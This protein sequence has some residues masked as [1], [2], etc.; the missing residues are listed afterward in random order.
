MAAP[1]TDGVLGLGG[2]G[3][4]TGKW[5][6]ACC[7]LEGTVWGGE[8]KGGTPGDCQVSGLSRGL[9]RVDIYGDGE[10]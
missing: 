6:W 3:R 9:H 10:E 5:M 2:E 1:R 7:I 4:D 8:G